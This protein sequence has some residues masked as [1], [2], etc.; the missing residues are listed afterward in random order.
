MD[1]IKKRP[2][3]A[4]RDEG[5]GRETNDD[6]V[7]GKRWRWNGTAREYEERTG[8]ERESKEKVAEKGGK[9]GGGEREKRGTGG[10]KT[11]REAKGTAA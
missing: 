5:N 11:E 3:E 1:F 8:E 7:E 4:Q 9:E 10:G 2:R 6:K